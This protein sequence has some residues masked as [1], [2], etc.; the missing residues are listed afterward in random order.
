MKW[1]FAA[2][3]VLAAWLLLSKNNSLVPAEPGTAKKPDLVSEL[4]PQNE[5]AQA[6]TMPADTGIEQQHTQAK[7]DSELVESSS[8]L[9]LDGRGCT[10]DLHENWHL[11][12]ISKNRSLLS[13]ELEAVLKSWNFKEAAEQLYYSKQKADDH[14]TELK[15]EQLMLTAVQKFQAES[16]GLGC[17]DN[18]CLMQITVPREIKVD[19]VRHLLNAPDL[20]WR[21]LSMSK[22][23]SKYHWRLRFV[24]SVDEHSVIAKY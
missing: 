24:A 6:A 20:S 10:L 12:L 22:R 15:L 3:I 2:V 17:R 19:E 14:K 16:E 21:T 8:A 11:K 13:R 5:A 1:I 18:I 9:C 7:P 4:L 23:K